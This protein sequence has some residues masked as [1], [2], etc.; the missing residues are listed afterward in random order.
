MK[1]FSGVLLVFAIIA[2][3]AMNVSAQFVPSLREFTGF[4][5][6]TFNGADEGTAGAALALN[7]SPRIGIEGEGSVIFANDTIIN[8]NADLLF[9]LGTGTSPIVPYLIGGAGILTNGG[10]D[11]AL[12]V[13][14]GLKL[15]VEPAIAI[16]L[17]FRGF[18]ISESGDIEDLERIYG[19]L[20]FFF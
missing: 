18:F 19:G 5:G 12:N 7:I 15:F 9:H 4:G 20:I 13:G 14:F 1:K 3:Y 2:G 11:V 17:D 10:T 8:L 16:R 6:M